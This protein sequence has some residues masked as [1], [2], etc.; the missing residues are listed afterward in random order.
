MG[1][2]LKLKKKV[3]QVEFSKRLVLNLKYQFYG[4]LAIALMFA[5]IGKDTSIFIVLLSVSGGLY[6]AGIVFYLNKSKME[7]IFKGKTECFLQKLELIEKYPSRRNEIES[8]FNENEGALTSKIS[9]EMHQS[10]QEEITR[11]MY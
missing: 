9:N 8:E 4:I 5:W 1:K 7:N 6:G 10:V 11:Q 3:K 2:K